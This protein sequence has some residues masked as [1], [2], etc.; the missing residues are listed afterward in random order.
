M[1]PIDI[2][3]VRKG[4]DSGNIPPAVSDA[5]SAHP[6]NKCSFCDADREPRAMIAFCGREPKTPIRTFG[7][8]TV[9]ARHDD[10]KLAEMTQREVFRDGVVCLPPRFTL[11]NFNHPDDLLEAAARLTLRLSQRCDW[12]EGCEDTD[13]P[14]DPDSWDSLYVRIGDLMGA[15]VHSREGKGEDPDILMTRFAG[16]VAHIIASVPSLRAA[17]ATALAAKPDNDP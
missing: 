16:S 1:Q 6:H 15:Y 3:I 8:C 10:E 7:V 17:V 4:R 5:I 12:V 9:C 11:D 14:N 2:W 13:D